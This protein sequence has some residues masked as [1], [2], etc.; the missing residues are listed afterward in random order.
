MNKKGSLL[1][2]ISAFSLVFSLISIIYIFI[3]IFSFTAINDN[4]FYNLQNITE[5]LE[6]DGIVTNGTSALTQTFGDDFRNFNLK[7][8]DLWLIAYTVFIMNSLVL[9]YKVSRLN[10]FSFL[11]FLF[12]GMMFILLLLSIFTTTTDWFKDEI[13]TAIIPSAY[14][15][16]PKFYYYLDHIGIFS[17]IHLGLCL[18]INMVDFDFLGINRRKKQEELVLNDSEVL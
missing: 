17:A 12:Y 1:I 13:L 6:H 10:Y 4:L 18:L 3:S 8:D 9:S 2:R 14:I 15:L 7:T 16:V 11:G 5:S